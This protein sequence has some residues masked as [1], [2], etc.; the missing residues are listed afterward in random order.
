MVLYEWNNG[1]MASRLV[2]TRASL[3][4]IIIIIITAFIFFTVLFIDARLFLTFIL[5]IILVRGAALIL[6][7]TVSLVVIDAAVGGGPLA[8]DLLLL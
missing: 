8:T 7:I 4:G 3:A 6:A 1:G 5:G 2:V